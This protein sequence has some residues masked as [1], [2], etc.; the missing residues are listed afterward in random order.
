MG[1][2]VQSKEKKEGKTLT[3]FKDNG[4]TKRALNQITERVTRGSPMGKMQENFSKKDP[5]KF[6]Q[7]VQKVAVNRKLKWEAREGARGDA[8][9]KIGKKPRV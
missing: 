1:L 4:F 3:L 9:R 7:S 8:F 5:D 2:A 6:L